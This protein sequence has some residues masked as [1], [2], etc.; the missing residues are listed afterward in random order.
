MK[1]PTHISLVS[2]GKWLA[3]LGFPLV[4]FYIGGLTIFL[5]CVCTA[6]LFPALRGWEKSLRRRFIRE[7]H[8]PL[9]I[10]RAVAATYPTLTEADTALVIKALRQFFLA[11][12]QSNGK[13]VSMPSQVVDVA[14]HELILH[15]AIYEK[16]CQ[17]AFGG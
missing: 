17:A 7:A 2:T 3:L 8:L 10:K 5:G 14:W 11:Y 12:S 6:M 1:L 9:S 13:F 4:S 16:W 15:T